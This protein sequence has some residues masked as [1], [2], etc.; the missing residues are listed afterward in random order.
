[1]ANEKEKKNLLRLT[2]L[3][4]AVWKISLA[5]AKSHVKHD[6]FVFNQIYILCVV[7]RHLSLFFH[8]RAAAAHIDGKNR[9]R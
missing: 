1:M 9:E 8:C 4:I 3:S 2:Q 6:H 7:G 5:I